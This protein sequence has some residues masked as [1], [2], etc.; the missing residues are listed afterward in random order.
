MFINYGWYYTLVNYRYYYSHTVLG[1]QTDTHVMRMQTV[2]WS[3][4]CPLPG[5]L[6]AP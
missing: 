5:I 4:H 6:L 2:M 1:T 3:L